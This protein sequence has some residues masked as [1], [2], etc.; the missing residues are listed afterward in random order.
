MAEI[1]VLGLDGHMAW[2]VTTGDLNGDGRH[3]IV[4][5]SYDGY[6]LMVNP[7]AGTIEDPL[8]YAVTKEFKTPSGSPIVDLAIG[9]LKGTTTRQVVAAS[10]D[11][12][13]Y[14]LDENLNLMWVKK[15]DATSVTQVKIGRLP[16]GAGGRGNVIAT[17]AS[18]K[19]FKFPVDY[20]GANPLPTPVLLTYYPHIMRVGTFLGDGKDTAFLLEARQDNRKYSPQLYGANALTGV[21]ER[22]SD[23]V[24]LASYGPF[25]PP[26]GQLGIELTVAP[27]WNAGSGALQPGKMTIATRYGLAQYDT[28]T[29]TPA[30]VNKTPETFETDLPSLFPKPNISY[31]YRAEK[32]AMGEL[33]SSSAGPEILVANGPDVALLAAD[34]H[35]L[36]IAQ[37]GI[38]ADRDIKTLLPGPVQPRGFTDAAYLPKGAS[39]QIVFA[40]SPNGDDNLYLVAFDNNWKDE[41]RSLKSP[42]P[43]Y[44]SAPSDPA[45]VAAKIDETNKVD[46]STYYNLKYISERSTSWVSGSFNSGAFTN[47]NSQSGPYSITIS[48]SP[49]VVPVPNTNGN[50]L[51]WAA[52]DLLA[53][54]S[55]FR[56]P[57][58]DSGKYPAADFPRVRFDV[59][60]LA[61]MAGAET[62]YSTTNTYHRD[63]RYADS[64]YV[65]KDFDLKRFF[66][67][68]ALHKV[69]FWLWIGHGAEPYLTKNVLSA[70]WLW[71]NPYF[72]GFIQ[73]ENERGIDLVNYITDVM[74]PVLEAI[75]A[76]AD[77]I[78]MPNR[79][80]VMR[81]KGAFWAASVAVPEVASI[82]FQPQYRRFLVPSVEESNARSA[83]LNLAARVGAWL[84]GVVDSW[85]SHFAPDW[86]RF[87]VMT[88]NGYP[89]A[90]HLAFRYMVAE[91]ALG[92]TSFS[93]FIGIGVPR[94]D[95]GIDPFIRLLGR[96]II[97]PPKR[98]QLKSVSPIVLRVRRTQEPGSEGGPVATRFYATSVNGHAMDSYDQ[99]IGMKDDPAKAWPFGQLDVYWGLAATKPTDVSTLLWKR[100]I[101]FASHIPPTPEFGFVSVI[102]GPPRSASWNSTT[103]W[104]TDGDFLYRNGGA[105]A[106]GTTFGPTAVDQQ[107]AQ[108]AFESDLKNASVSFPIQLVAVDG[109]D[110]FYSVVELSSTASESKYVLYLVD[111]G[112]LTPK[113]RSANFKLIKL[114]SN[115][116]WTAVDRLN[117][118]AGSVTVSDGTVAAGARLFTNVSAGSMRVIELT[119]TTN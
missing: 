23:E 116:Q 72:L 63:P 5:G 92:A 119:R 74:K 75:V 66:D 53:E 97:A 85:D 20:V 87:N 28:S 112:F 88:S 77:T 68:M 26:D 103:R 17:T 114:T 27:A 31:T 18:K 98:Q 41:L 47:A 4:V 52:D 51:E 58:D 7:R 104:E 91:L 2:Q 62:S 21:M 24:P 32:V 69:P 57:Q 12:R 13:V 83:D 44:Q 90:G 78:G 115:Q 8:A 11:G 86:S 9:N 49:K 22:I 102:S 113:L 65:L 43:S 71:S 19:L 84:D 99:R 39:G 3:E 45:Y 79:K 29:A 15:L 93:P 50:N 100:R 76:N 105:Y 42:F 101:Q 94:A 95:E 33:T 38:P 73:A 36:G 80:L 111:P 35:V 106:G 34:G 16:G 108:F 40:S 59:E 118:S 96:G 110:V 56:N 117:P 54:I 37:V 55:T 61:T 30:L 6:V 64:H 46:R 107:A 82:L 109:I 48:K 1:R 67:R 10:S 70:P 60:V 81:E 14:A 89:L 25:T